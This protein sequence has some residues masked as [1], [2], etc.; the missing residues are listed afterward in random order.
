M[1]NGFETETPGYLQTVDIET[2]QISAR[3]TPVPLGNLDGVVSDGK[4]GYVLTDWMKGNVFRIGTDGDPK[5]W[6]PLE[7]GTADLGVLPGKGV[8]I[9]NMNAGTISLYSLEK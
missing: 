9:P 7:P 4:D 3:F 5:L 2:K 1:T 8:V 6:L